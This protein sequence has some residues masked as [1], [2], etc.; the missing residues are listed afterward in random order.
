MA[1]ARRGHGK[2]LATEDARRLFDFDTVPRSQVEIEE[3]EYDIRG[4]V[5]RGVSRGR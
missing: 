5:E 3:A 2:S 1:A 4:E